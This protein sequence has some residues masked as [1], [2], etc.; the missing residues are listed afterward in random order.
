M[1]LHK[2]CLK[3]L[4]GWLKSAAFEQLP[5]K[6]ISRSRAES[7]LANPHAQAGDVVLYYFEE[8]NQI[9]AF[10]TVLPAIVDAGNE[11]FAWLSGMWT[12]PR[13]RRRG[14]P[15]RL[16][17]EACADWQNKVAVINF[18]PLAKLLYEKSGLLGP[19]QELAGKRFYLF[20]KSKKI[21]EQRLGN[22]FFLWPLIDA[23][24][25]AKAESRLKKFQPV[26]HENFRWEQQAFPD[27]ECLE[28]ADRQ[29]P[30]FLFRRGTAELKWILAWPWL[31]ADDR[32]FE[33]NYPFGSYV[34]QFEVYT[35]KFFER[36]RFA[37]FLI[38]SVRNGQLKLLHL[39]LTT[40]CTTAVAAFLLNE[41][42]DRR[43]EMLTVLNE[44]VA[45]ALSRLQHPF[46]MTRPYTLPVYTGQ[47]DL[48]KNR[49]LQPA[50]GD[51]I[52]T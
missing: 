12:H 14:L 34:V 40:G 31:S 37:G 32:S 28:L 30:G 52:F 36:G 26:H 20:V 25:A 45:N 51:F 22:L 16:L 1:E 29:Q 8:G 9:L 39:N 49:R 5:V 33:Y 23:W 13:Y 27:R 35:V 15:R 10:R 41:S 17:A 7:Y 24:A 47:L 19:A 11:R 38:Y 6:P 2:I 50:E 42:V 46:V 18:S 3:D 44:P 48:P 43:I 4:D 21:L